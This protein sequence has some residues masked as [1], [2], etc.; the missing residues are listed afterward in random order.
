MNYIRKH[1]CQQIM[2]GFTNHFDTLPDNIIEIILKNNYPIEVYKSKNNELENKKK[3]LKDVIHTIVLYT[4]KEY[5]TKQQIDKL[6]KLDNKVKSKSKIF[7][8]RLDNLVIKKNFY[9][10]CDLTKCLYMDIIKRSIGI[11]RIK[12][13]LINSNKKHLLL[14]ND[15]G[16]LWHRNFISS[17]YNYELQKC[18]CGNYC[19]TDNC[20]IDSSGL[21]FHFNNFRHTKKHNYKLNQIIKNEKKISE[22]G[23]KLRFCV[24]CN[25]PLKLESVKQHFNSNQHKNNCKH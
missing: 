5:Y 22:Y 3:I 7:E 10:D 14:L 11:N 13:Y 18:I 20:N 15:C 23:D 21:S 19:R 2:D 25:K 6:F 12:K 17:I 4:G 9:K 24:D 1:D 8:K 16:L